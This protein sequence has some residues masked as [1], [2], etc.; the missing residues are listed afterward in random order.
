MDTDRLEKQLPAWNRLMYM[1][2]SSAVILL[3]A[4]I[5]DLRWLRWVAWFVLQIL[6]TSIG[7]NLLWG[8]SW[9][10]LPLS[11]ERINIVFGY[12]LASWLL[13]FIPMILARLACLAV[14][15]LIYSIFLLI[16]YLRTRKKLDESEE[17]FP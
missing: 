17:M 15:L 8:K 11:K 6:V 4:S 9:K 16:I 10:S 2:M 7:F 12:F 14:P 5:D 13:L 1:A 3:V